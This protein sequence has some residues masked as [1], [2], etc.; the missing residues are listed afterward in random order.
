MAP[1]SSIHA[2][3][4]RL[5]ASDLDGTLL[6]SDGTLSERTLGAVRAVREAGIDLVVLTA[7][8]PRGLAREADR[9]D[10][11][12]GICCNGAVTHDFTLDRPLH[13]RTLPHAVARRL[14]ESVREA[15]PGIAL[16]WEHRGGFQAEPHYV[17]MYVP[18]DQV[19]R[20]DPL[21]LEFLPPLTKLVLQHHELDQADLHD[22]AAELCG[23]HAIATYSGARLV[24]IAAAG[25]TKA[26]ALA[27]LCA[28]RGFDAAQ[29]LAFGDMPNDVPMLRW[30]GRG[31]AVANG[32]PD[33]LAAADEVAAS[34]DEDGVAAVL[35]LLLA[36]G[37]PAG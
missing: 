23:E 21:S 34:N 3:E 20:A 36:S 1:S 32:H 15:A 30:A 26:S 18:P 16:G 27:E 24:E 28:E 11:K 22:L 19:P 12:L 35:E 33:A 29:V 14:I 13:E 37:E 7:R 4:T 6:R 9:L 25:V 8:S 10:L 5:V 17:P 31:V 2:G